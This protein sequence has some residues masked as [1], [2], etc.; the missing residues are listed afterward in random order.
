MGG[1]M[2]ETGLTHC[3][4]ACLEVQEVMGKVSASTTH[5]IK[6][7]LAVL[8][9]QAGLLQ[10]LAQIA[11]DAGGLDV[12]KVQNLSRRIIERVGLSNDIVKRYNSFAHLSDNAVGPVYAEEI[13]DLMVGIYRRLA[14]MKPVSLAVQKAHPE[15]ELISRP[16]LLAAALFKC[17]QMAVI[18]A[19]ARGEV[20]ARVVDLDADA[21]F[22][23][24]WQDGK[25]EVQGGPGPALLESLHARL[26]ELPGGGGL[27]LVVPHK[28][29]YADQVLK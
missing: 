9:E 17:L 27:S 26:Q 22:E 11:S 25:L 12:E 8:S 7:Q 24:S 21:G 29:P 28:W 1:T 15:L 2:R 6:N 23:F 16:M 14:G 19:P 20:T 3:N 4:L 5:E 10:D 13:V 18:A